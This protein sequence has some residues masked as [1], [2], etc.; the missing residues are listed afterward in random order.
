[1]LS[2]FSRLGFHEDVNLFNISTKAVKGLFKSN[3]IS[4]RKIPFENHPVWVDDAD[5]KLGYHL[6]HTSLPRPGGFAQ[7]EAMAGR[8]MAQ[9]LDRSRPLWECWVLEGLEG[10]IRCTRSGRHAELLGKAESG[11]CMTLV[12]QSC[13][14]DRCRW[15]ASAAARAD[16]GCGSGSPGGAR[17]DSRDSAAGGLTSVTGPRCRDTYV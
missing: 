2:G 14:S 10:S 4:V 11:A 17:C 6:R 16:R 5:F 12:A 8:I 9:Q 3:G 1:M 15:R 13:P 7:L